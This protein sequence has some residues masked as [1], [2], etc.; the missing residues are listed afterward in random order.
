MSRDL[1][2]HQRLDLALAAHGGLD[3]P[4]CT[5]AIYVWRS[6]L[7]RLFYLISS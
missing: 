4:H 1:C 6:A 3:G 2:I 7:A 5:V